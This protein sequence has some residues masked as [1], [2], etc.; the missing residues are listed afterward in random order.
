MKHITVV[1]FPKKR[2][3]QGSEGEEG[4]GWEGK[5]KKVER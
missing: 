3:T 5:E 4:K 1:V 2:K